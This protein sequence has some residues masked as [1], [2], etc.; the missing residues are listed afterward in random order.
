MKHAPV[1]G[2]A[3]GQL[4][5]DQHLVGCE[6]GGEK[7]AEEIAEAAI[8]RPPGRRVRRMRAPMAPDDGGQLGSRIGM[9][10]VAADRAA[11]ADLRVGDVRQRFG[12][13]RAG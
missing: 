7:A 10:K 4:D 11:I 13:Q 5:L 9:C 1:R 3:C 12:K 6:R 2:A 8:H